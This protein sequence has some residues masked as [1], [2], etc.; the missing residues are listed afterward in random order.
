MR[1]KASYKGHPLHPALIPFPFAFLTGALVFDLIGVLTSG[2]GWFTTA[3]YLAAAG[4]LTALLAA[5]PGFID[6]LYTVPPDSSGK[7]RATKHML[8]NLS[9]VV[10]FAAAWLLRPDTP[11]SPGAAVIGLETVGVVLLSMGGW[12]GGTLVY[13]NMSGVD[14]RYAEAGKWSEASLSGSPGK[15]ISVARADELQ[16]NQMKLLRIGDRRV[17]LG[18]TETGYVAFDDRCSHRGASLAGGVMI[19]STV[20]CLW[21]GS[22]FDVSDGSVKAGPAEKPIQT[23]PVAV[24]GNE[25]LLSL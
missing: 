5:V 10:V 11:G 20:H 23:Y 4:V 9:A 6:Y 19:C 7:Q 13:R 3:G 8:L 14:H 25:V 21:H 18:R 16:V 2:D 12:M 22:H 1:S 15:P 24:Q 17:V